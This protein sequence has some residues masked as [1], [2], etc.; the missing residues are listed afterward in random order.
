[1][2][3]FKSDTHQYFTKDNRELI[4]VSKFTERFEPKENWDEIAT[5]YAK[6]HG[7]NKKDVQALWAEKAKKGKEA[8]TILH[9]IREADLLKKDFFEFEKMKLMHKV[10]PVSEGCKW[11]LPINEVQN[12]HVYPE[13]MIY[14]TDFM[15]CGQSDK[16]IVENNK[17]HI[18]DYKTDK[19]LDFKGFIDPLGHEKKLLPPLQHLGNCNGNLYSIKMSLYMYLICKANA[20]RFKPGRIILEWCPLER[21]ADEMPILYNGK[22]KVK[23]Q[24]NIELPYRKKEIIDMLRTI[25]TN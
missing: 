22:P 3:K 19:K 18:Y 23:F 17:I 6:K 25:K 14:D 1:M 24:K 8:G 20:G 5:K 10:C 13:M 7:L 2:I 4:S 11:A 15:V 12:G 16:V 9:N 21:D